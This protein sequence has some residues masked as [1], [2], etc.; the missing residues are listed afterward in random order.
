MPQ[1]T[2]S[3]YGYHQCT[4]C[5]DW[6]SRN[7]K[8]PEFYCS[9]DLGLWPQ[10]EGVYHETQEQKEQ[11]EIFEGEGYC[12][13]CGCI[14]ESIDTAFCSEECIDDYTSLPLIS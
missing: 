8:D 5:G 1:K 6:K 3:N 12:I 4:F 13:M 14:M 9:C 2:E 10:G 11:P 7:K